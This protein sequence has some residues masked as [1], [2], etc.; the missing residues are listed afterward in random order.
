MTFFE[1]YEPFAVQIQNETGVPAA[2]IL[3]QAALESNYGKSAPGNNFFGVKGV[4]PAGGQ[5]LWTTEVYNGKPTRVQATFRKYISP[6]DSFRDHAR[7]ISTSPYYRGVMKA[8][9]TGDIDQI[10]KAIGDSPY[11]TDPQYGNKILTMMKKNKLDDLV[12]SRSGVQKAVDAVGEAIPSLVKPALAA[13]ETAGQKYGVGVYKP[14]ATIAQQYT[15]YTVKAGD[16]PGAIAQQYLGDW[17]RWKEL[18]QGDP[19]RLPIGAV[20]KVPQP[21][22]QPTPIPTPQQIVS[23]GQSSRNVFNQP[24]VRYSAPTRPAPVPTPVRVPAPSVARPVVSGQST[25]DIFGR[26]TV[27]YK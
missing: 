22:P 1:Q 12:P 15:P 14:T 27:V 8:A 26:P 24:T 9:K 21:T 13:E 25:R 23:G 17:N 2:L 11:A 3:A 10:A 16:T 18:W 19:R 5:Y 4:G 7:L 20:L 6:A